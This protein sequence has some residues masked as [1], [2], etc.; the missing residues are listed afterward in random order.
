MAITEEQFSGQVEDLLKMLG[1]RWCHF[2]PARTEKGWR[3]ALTGDKG[4]PD[5]IAARPPRLIFAE[6][7]SEDGEL[8]PEQEGWIAALKKDL[9]VKN[10]GYYYLAASIL[11]YRDLGNNEYLIETITPEVYLWRPNQIEEIAEILS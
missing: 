5:I 1:W 10:Y 2:R 11:S 4:L 8:S 9:G 3:T 6:L 7:K